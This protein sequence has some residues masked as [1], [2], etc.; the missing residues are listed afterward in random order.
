[1][2]SEKCSKKEYLEI[3]LLES[4]PMLAKGGFTPLAAVCIDIVVEPESGRGLVADPRH[5]ATAPA[6][7]ADL[8]T[9]S[10]IQYCVEGASMDAGTV[11]VAWASVASESEGQHGVPPAG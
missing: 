2:K 9:H 10:V 6:W 4:G 7:S 8:C 11:S 1:M 3:R 5:V